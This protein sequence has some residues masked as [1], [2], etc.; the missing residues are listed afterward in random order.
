MPTL[1]DNFNKR[2]FW[3][4][5]N[6][7]Y[8]K[9]SF[10]AK[11][12]AGIIAEITKGERCDLLDIGCGPASLCQVVGSNINYHGMDIAI[13]QPAP[14]LRELDFAQNVISFDDK[15]FRIVVSLGV[16]EYM[17]R[18]QAQKFEEISRI[19]E[20]GGTFIMSYVNFQHFRK[21]I[22][23]MYNN[24]QLVDDMRR[25]LEQTFTVERCFPVCHHWRHKQPG[26]NALPALQAKWESTIPVISRLFA[27]EYF[28]VCSRR[29]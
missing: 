4:E 24:V 15:R 9:P 18:Y 11:K 12:C 28:F 13:H 3:I 5:E 14:Y 21:K 16:F 26:K 17:G 7:V 20:P 23:S 27:V 25:G 10:R 19:L 6:L 22:Y 29:G 1:T 2:D 8:A